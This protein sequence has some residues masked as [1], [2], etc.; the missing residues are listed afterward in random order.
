[1]LVERIIAVV[2]SVL[3]IL[4]GFYLLANGMGVIMLNSYL[5]A[6]GL[7]LIAGGV[8]ALALVAASGDFLFYLARAILKRGSEK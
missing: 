8:F 2:L 1:V 7:G 4:F 3:G 6:A 5:H